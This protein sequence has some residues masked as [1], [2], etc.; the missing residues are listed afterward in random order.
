MKKA[1]KWGAV[2]LGIIF[3]ALA[4]YYWLTPAGSLPTFVPGYEAGSATIHVKHG[5]GAL[6][7]GILLFI[8]AWFSS[9][10]KSRSQES[11]SE[12]AQ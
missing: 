4:A 12:V 9:G 2:V 6:I 5:L 11:T 1:I 8:F 3:I 10:K 7:V